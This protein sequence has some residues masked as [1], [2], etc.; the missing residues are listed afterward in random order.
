VKIALPATPPYLPAMHDDAAS[1]ADSERLLVL[2]GY[3][4]FLIA[5]PAGGLTALI[6]VVIAHIRLAHAMGSIHESHYRNQIRVFWTMLIFAIVMMMLFTM[7]MGFSIFS[8]AWPFSFGWPLWPGAIVGVGWAMLLPLAGLLSLLLVV[9]Y[10][11]RLLRGF[12]RALDD[13]PY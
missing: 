8:L 5:P 12:V 2:L 6:G 11:W 3:G 1:R 7:G 4:L 13:K 9:W 10:Y